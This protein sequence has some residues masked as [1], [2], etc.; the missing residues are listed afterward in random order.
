MLGG[1][2]LLGAGCRNGSVPPGAPAFSPAGA[3][4]AALAEY[5]SNKDGALD[6]KEL[7]QCPGLQEAFKRGLDKNKDGRVTADEIT[8]RLFIF[9]QEG[10]IGSVF[11][12]ASLDGKP[13]G[14]ATITLTPE[15]FMGPSFQP[16]TKNTEPTGTTMLPVVYYG[17]YRVEVSKKGAGGKETIPARYNTQTT[18]GREVAPAR[19][20]NRR[21]S[22]DDPLVLRLT[23]R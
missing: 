10:M 14:D 21:G 5:D 6:A 16:V 15:K 1:L 13:L 7:E 19:A 22:G 11:V 18:L 23:S 4:A 20:Q 17:Y 2:V 9:Q 8:D 3:A 12:Q